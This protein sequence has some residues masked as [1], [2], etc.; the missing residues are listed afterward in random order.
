MARI[1]YNGP[2]ESINVEPYG[3]HVRGT[4]KEYPDDFAVDLIA[5]SRKQKF[6]RMPEALPETPTDGAPQSPPD[7]GHDSAVRPP[8]SP[9][10]EDVTPEL[11]VKKAKKKKG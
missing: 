5:T 8:A 6:E 2:S 3:R 9:A 11:S 4:V 7:G 10:A 1:K